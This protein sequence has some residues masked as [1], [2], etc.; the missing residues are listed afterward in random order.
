MKRNEKNASCLSPNRKPMGFTLIELLVVIAIIAILAAMLLPA[1][2][3]ARER[4]RSANCMNKLKQIGLATLAYANDS[5]DFVPVKGALRSGCSCKNCYYAVKNYYQGS[6][7]T[8]A[9]CPPAVLLYS[10]YLAQ[11]KIGNMQQ[12]DSF[13]CPSDTSYY[14]GNAISYY[15]AVVGHGTDVISKVSKSYQCSPRIRI[16][17]D[18]P[19]L[20]FYYDAASFGSGAKPMIHPNVINVL[21]FGGHVENV[22]TTEDKVKTYGMEAFVVNIL[23]PQNKDN[24]GAPSA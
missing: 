12:K 13:R 20:T 14:S 24:Y 9:G 15:Y 19:N 5:H 23:E 8:G 10:K 16:G 21:R 7:S 6:S 3:A 18:D 22:N 17:R 2:S 11:D 1:L 4:A